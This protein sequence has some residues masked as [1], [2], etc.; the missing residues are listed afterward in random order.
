MPDAIVDVVR[1][2]H[3]T[4]LCKPNGGVRGIVAGDMVRR[5]VARTDLTADIQSGGA[6]HVPF[7]ICSID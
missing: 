2:G 7:P 3:M 5:L 1:S 6:G 4:A